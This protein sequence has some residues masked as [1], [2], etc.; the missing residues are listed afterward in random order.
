MTTKNENSKELNLIGPGTIIEGK[1]RSKG[2]IR[3]DGKVMGELY[4]S[5][6]VSVGQSGE[7]EGSVSAKNVSVG[8]KIRGSITAQE[9]LVFE[10]KAIVQGDIKAAKLIID[11]G[12]IFDGNCTMSNAKPNIS[13][14]LQPKTS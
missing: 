4:A 1:L 13:S 10:S 7:I 9:K 6:T 8:G 2:N 5:E 14:N 12:A 3:I 11:E